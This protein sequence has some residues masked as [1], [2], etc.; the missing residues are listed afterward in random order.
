MAIGTDRRRGIEAWL[1][2]GVV[3]TGSLATATPVLC[4]DVVINEV[5][6]QN[7]SE[8]PLDI[9]GNAEPMIELRNLTDEVLRLGS[10]SAAE[11]YSISFSP[12]FDEI[13][14][15]RLRHLATIPP[16]GHVV[17]FADNDAV[18]ALCELHVRGLPK[19][20]NVP[21]SL[22][23][24]EDESGVRPLVDQIWVPPVP[25][26]FSVRRFPDGAGPAPV[27]A[28]ETLDVLQIVRPG[29][30]SFGRCFTTGANCPAGLLQRYCEGSENLATEP[31]GAR[32]RLESFSTNAP[33]AGEAVSLAVRVDAADPLSVVEVRLRYSVDDVD[34]APVTCEF[35]A[36]IGV[37]EEPATRYGIWRGSI[38][39]QAAGSVVQFVI[40]A[41]DV[42]DT[43]E[44]HPP[45]VCPDDV[46]CDA[47]WIRCEPALRFVCG[48]V[49]EDVLVLNE[50]S[51]TSL[52]RPEI[53]DFAEILNTS[54]SP[55]D[56][57]GIWLS[58]RPFRPERW[59]FPEGTTMG[60]GEYL[61]VLLDDSG[62]F[63]LDT[64][65]PEFREYFAN[66]QLDEEGE[67][68]Y[69]FDSKA[70][71]FGVLDGT[72]FSSQL[73]GQSQSRFP[74][75]DRDGVY[76]STSRA[77]PG[78]ENSFLGFLRGD[79]NSNCRLGLTD[80]VFLL[81]FLFLSG[82]RPPCADSA[83]SDDSGELDLSDVIFVLNFLFLGGPEPPLPGTEPGP[84][85]TEDRLPVCTRSPC[86]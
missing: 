19:S 17:L 3:L 74:D 45:R 73:G 32:P 57:T 15:V 60:P 82:P 40:E 58:D 66:F 6:L 14:A 53:N 61:V 24:P 47:V 13:R 72:Q 69:L 83:D 44:T 52:L 39:G 59:Q 65:M 8:S 28:A 38:P 4:Q 12:V 5:L 18:E 26:G 50:F 77:T 23:G 55:V 41:V 51:A 22:W 68:L 67:A 29:E 31:V 42:S 2:G 63:C 79:A 86:L 34:Q 30:S 25:D 1:L 35:D 64:S 36:E 46:P 84:D 10:D 76:V 75:G 85:P 54:E 56:L 7:R 70:N 20:G 78:G 11:S 33:R 21:V 37:V 49:P 16:N 81:T 62:N 48:F 71:S 9:N 27:P 80:A 43:A